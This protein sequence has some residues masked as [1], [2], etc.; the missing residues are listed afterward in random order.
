[1]ARNAL[2]RV[3]PDTPLVI[4]TG[5]PEGDA[6]ADETRAPP[7]KARPATSGRASFRAHGG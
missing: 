6:A 5:E 7:T 2:E 1:M 3:D 4:E